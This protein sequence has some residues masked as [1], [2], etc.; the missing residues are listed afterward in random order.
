MQILDTNAISLGLL[1]AGKQRSDGKLHE[2]LWIVSQLKSNKEV[3]SS[4]VKITGQL[5]ENSPN[6]SL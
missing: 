1:H 2:Y 3:I 4:I 5:I 6:V